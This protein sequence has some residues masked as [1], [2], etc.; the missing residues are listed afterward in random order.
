MEGIV[1]AGLFS[2]VS[3]AFIVNMQSSLSPSASDTTNSLLKILINKVDNTT[4]PLQEAALPVWTGPSSTTIWIQTLAYT[5]LSSSLL[6]AFGAVLAKQWLGNFKTSRFGKGALHER[7]QRR[8]QKLDGLETWYFSTILATLPIFLQL[9]LCFFGISLAANIWT[10]Q[11]TVASVIM[12]TTAFGLIFYFFTVV[13]SLKSPDCPFQTPVSSVIQL[14]LRETARFLAVVREKWDK[15]PLS[16]EDFLYF[17]RES[18]GRVF[19][20]VKRLIATSIT[21]FVAYLPR[22]PSGLRQ[23]RSTATNPEVAGGTEPVGTA[24]HTDQ[25]APVEGLDLGLLDLPIEIAQVHAAQSSAVQ[26][27]LETSTDIDNV[28]A[29]AG[30]VPEIEWP[31][32]EDVTGALDRLESQFYAC[33]DPTRGM[34]PLARSRA[35]A[36][37]KAT[38]HFSVE[39]DLRNPFHILPDGAV[40]SRDIYEFYRMVPDPA[41]LMV[42]A[43]YHPVKLNISSLPVSDRMWMAH[44]FTHRLRNGERHPDIVSSMIDFI[45]I[46]LDSKFPARL[47]ADCLLLA[48]M[49][50]GLPV[51]QRQLVRLDKR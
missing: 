26:W 51:D 31:A 12:A 6:A 40:F 36:C 18:S 2:A 49:L 7:C 33:F 44:M 43:V 23:V 34:L 46:C 16:W 24:G 42:C 39:R 50:V 19:N 38:C 22:V 37:L 47:V 48:G 28:E 35:L 29:A 15:H 45:G 14:S 30:M 8:Q 25:T 1:Q 5:S 27:I 4:F 41:Y 17:L 32:A 11:H 21:L 20:T 9:S 3:S 13:S 10:L